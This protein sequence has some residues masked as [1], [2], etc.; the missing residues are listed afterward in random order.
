MA[1]DGGSMTPSVWMEA[2]CGSVSGFRSDN[3][4]KPENCQETA[5]GGFFSTITG[6]RVHTL[7][8]G[9]TISDGEW[10]CPACTRKLRGE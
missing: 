7:S 4:H 8:Q 3:W 6:A 9:W 10:W 1:H 2:R 5:E